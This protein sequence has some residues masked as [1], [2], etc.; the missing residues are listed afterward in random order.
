M[1][2]PRAERIKTDPDP[3]E[4]FCLSQGFRVG[5]VI[6]LS[7]QAALDLE[8]NIIG[9][10]DFD[11]QA[12]QVFRNIDQLL[13]TAGSSLAEV[14]KVTIYLTDMS[15]FPKVI[16]LRRKW[17]TAPYPADSIVEVRALALPELMIEIEA[18]AIAGVRKTG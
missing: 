14:V 17:F 16:E 3:F 7:G 8:G 10:G 1:Q 5:D 2:N 18:M 12:D 9:A 15:H 6:Y 11:A 13:T 4:P